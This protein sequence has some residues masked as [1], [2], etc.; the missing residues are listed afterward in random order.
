MIFDLCW[1]VTE[2]LL[3]GSQEQRV[4]DRQV[5]GSEMGFIVPPMAVSAWIWRSPGLPGTAGLGRWIWA[6]RTSWKDIG[7]APPRRGEGWVVDIK[8]FARHLGYISDV[9]KLPDS[10]AC[11]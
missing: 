8:L 6:W 3:D 10:P 4:E 11:Y 5:S 9:L 2:N 7:Q 1:D